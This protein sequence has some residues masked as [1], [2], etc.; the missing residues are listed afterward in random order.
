MVEKSKER[1]YG[2]EYLTCDNIV[3]QAYRALTM[4]IVE[5]IIFVVR[6]VLVVIVCILFRV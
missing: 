1:S 6:I 5:L 4:S 2:V 3:M